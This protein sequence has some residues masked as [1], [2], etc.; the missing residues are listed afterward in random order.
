MELGTARGVPGA[1]PRESERNESR[2][3]QKEPRKK[4]CLPAAAW[5]TSPPGCNTL[6]SGELA[7]V[8]Q[9]VKGG[10]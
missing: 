4:R 2:T 7:Q 3:V 5:R 9:E 6:T 1:E 10:E 8:S